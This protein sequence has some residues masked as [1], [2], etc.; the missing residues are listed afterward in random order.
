MFKMKH[1]NKKLMGNYDFDQQRR[2]SAGDKVAKNIDGHICVTE[3]IND[4]M[5]VVTPLERNLLK[6]WED[7]HIPKEVRERLQKLDR[8]L[9]GEEE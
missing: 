6:M 5:A 3:I 4:R 9:R 2:L 1:Q 8:I 7:R